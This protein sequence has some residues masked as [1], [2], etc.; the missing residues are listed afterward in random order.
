[1]FQAGKAS[2]S[3]KATCQK[4]TAQRKKAQAKQVANTKSVLLA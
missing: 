2:K 4:A 1:M 3:M